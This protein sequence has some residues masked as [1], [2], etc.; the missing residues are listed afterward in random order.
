MTKKS[1][2]I[3]GNEIVKNAFHFARR[4]FYLLIICFACFLTAASTA[5]DMF[6]PGE[7]W[8]DTSGQPINAHGGGIL[9]HDDVYYWFGEHKIEGT[10]GNKAMV[11]VHCYASKDLLQW[12]DEG[13]ALAVEHDPE[14]EIT[15]GCI[16]ERPKVLFSKVTGKFVMWFHLE[17]K[18]T[19]Y[20]SARSGVA[21]A[22]K[23][24]GPYRYLGSVR[25]CAGHWPPNVPEEWKKPLN[26]E[27]IV[28]IELLGLLGGPHPEYPSDLIFRRDFAGGQMARDMTLFRDTDGKSYHIY[29]SEENRTLQIAELSDDLLK[30][31]GKYV[32]VFPG[33]FNEA[34]AVMIHDNKYYLIASGCTGWAPNPARLAVAENI[35]GPWKELDNPCRGTAEQRA[36][37]FRSQGT[38]LLP[39]VGKKDAWIF[40]A[41]RWNPENAID[42]R[43]VWLPVRFEEHQPVLRWFDE[44]SL[45]IFD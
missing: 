13:I 24:T 42:G 44:W 8:N 28:K 37:T 29:S 40:M 45:D 35:F 7:I 39:V 33:R 43:Y 27:E 6:K 20:K 41:D 30:H 16:L 5:Q 11:G 15:E 1:V 17:L 10:A 23:V 19:G 26:S 9:F 38:F 25:P 31:T 2:T 12:K 32:R 36:T 14:S 4:C 18:A 34:P 22:S 21:V 3:I